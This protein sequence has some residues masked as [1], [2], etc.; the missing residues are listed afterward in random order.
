MIIGLTGYA[1]SG[2]DT[3]AKL[4]VNNYGYTRVAFADKVRELLLEIN[5]IMYNGGHLSSFVKEFGWDFAKNK[6]EVREMLQDLGLGVRDILGND[7]WIIA[8]L[9]Q[10]ND[11]NKNYV[12]T[13]VRFENEAFMIKQLGGQI[14]RIKKI[15]VEAVNSHISET[16]LE[17]Y[18]PDQIFTNNG[19]ID[20]L[21]TLIKVRMNGFQ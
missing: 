20:E 10:I 19:T 7:T 1:Q 13:D 5:P 6:P 2:K 21:E 9:S 17:N 8:A 4:L 12:I 14:W 15:G 18:K 3:V 16:E 11:P